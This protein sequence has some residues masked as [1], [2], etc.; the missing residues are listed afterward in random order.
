MKLIS[1]VFVF[2]ISTVPLFSNDWKNSF[3]LEFSPYFSLSKGCLNEYIYSS[4]DESIKKSKLEWNLNPLYQ[5]GIESKFGWKNIF[6]TEKIDFALP[7]G[8]GTLYD[9]DWN[10]TGDI[11][12]IYSKLEEKSDLIFNSS[13]GIGY[14]FNLKNKANDRKYFS[15]FPLIN[16][17][18]SYFKIKSDNGH[19]YFGAEN[20]SLN[21]TDVSWDSEYATYHKVYGIDLE[22]VYYNLF[23]GLAFEIY[24]TEKISF[25]CDFY[26][27][28]YSYIVTYDKHFAKSSWYNLN[29]YQQCS[30][31]YLKFSFFSNYKFSDKISINF[32]FGILN[33]NVAKGKFYH[34]YYSSKPT[35]S[36]QKSG[37]STILYDIKFGVTFSV[38]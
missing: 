19:G 24:P 10:S 31:E 7:V 37:S 13:F 3:L 38:L 35:L 28:A 20:Y 14:D 23:T 21:G 8:C 2:I 29:G 1:F 4:S 34:N 6:I 36:R 26:I 12:T 5:F 11:K 27:S 9:S 17:D 15:F 33:G 16:F 18:Y 30:F 25:G 22:R 32:K